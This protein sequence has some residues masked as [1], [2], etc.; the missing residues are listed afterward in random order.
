MVLHQQPFR[1]NLRSNHGRLLSHPNFK[2]LATLGDRAFVAPP[3]KLWN[4]LPL[5]IRMAKS[6]EQR[7]NFYLAKEYLQDGF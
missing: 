4:S 6:V 2:P 3:R 1:F 7:C 5:E